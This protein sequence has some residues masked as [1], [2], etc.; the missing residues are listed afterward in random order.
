MISIRRRKEITVLSLF[1]LA[2]NMVKP[3]S[4]AGFST[5]CIDVQRDGTDIL[6]WIPPRARY[7]IVFAFPPCTNLAVSGARWFQDKGLAGLGSA[8]ELV[9]RARDICEWAGAP[10]MIENPIST[11]S[12]YWRKPDH[13]FHP[14]EFAGLE[15]LDN[16][17]KKTCVWCGNGF[18][19]PTPNCCEMRRYRTIGFIWRPRRQS[20]RISEAPHRWDSHARFFKQMF[21]KFHLHQQKGAKDDTC[22]TDRSRNV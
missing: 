19:M 15:P 20:G 11:L 12:T 6:K 1:D 17:T 18:I 21:L 13:I 10:W 2:G 14:Y 3:W 16:Y 7:G 8:I 22:T 9:E 4:E 5:L